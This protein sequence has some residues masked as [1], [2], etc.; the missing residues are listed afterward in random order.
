[1]HY[2][3]YKLGMVLWL[4]DLHVAYLIQIRQLSTSC[5]TTSFSNIPWSSAKFR[6][7]FLSNHASQPL[8]TWYGA[9]ARGPTRRLPN[10]RPPVI[11]FL[12][13]IFVALFSANMHHSHLKF[14]IVLAVLHVAYRI[15]VRSYMYLLPVL[16]V[17]LFSDI[18]WSSAK[19]S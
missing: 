17:S 10:S 19:F 12:F 11:Y 1:M 9:S 4:G 15:H 18:T 16:R 14:F 3:L 7:T 13:Q 2:R 5:F 8:Q 6:S